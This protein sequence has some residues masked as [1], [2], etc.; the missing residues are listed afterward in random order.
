MIKNAKAKGSRREREVRDIFISKGYHV[1]KAGGSLGAFDLVAVAKTNLN[2]MFALI[3]V[4]SNYISPQEV[5]E[6]ADAPVNF[7]AEKQVWVKK[8]R[9]PWKMALIEEPQYNG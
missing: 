1:V 2:P 5:Q 8:D 3:Q 6:I 9:K 7:M 4:K